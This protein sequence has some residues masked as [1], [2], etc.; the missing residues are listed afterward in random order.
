MKA[1]E[2]FSAMKVGIRRNIKNICVIETTERQPTSEVSRKETI[3]H[4][5]SL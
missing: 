4:W 1:T 5:R 2:T 3:H